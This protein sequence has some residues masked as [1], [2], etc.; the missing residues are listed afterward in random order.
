MLANSRAQHT[1]LRQ[2]QGRWA[3]FAGLCLAFLAGSYALLAETWHPAYALRWLLIS[4]TASVYLLAVTWRNLPGNHRQGETQLLPTL[5]W[6]NRL[7]LLRGLFT[8]ALLGFLFSPL[9]PAQLVW[10]PGILYTLVCLADFLDGY[11]A[12]VTNHVTRLGESLDMSSDGLGVL[13]A[14]LLVV[15]YGQVPAWYLLVGLARYLFLAGLWSRRR[16]GKMIYELPPSISR[17]MFAGL[18][19]GFLAV[20]LWPLFSPPGTHIA[21]AF[22]GTPLLAGFLLDWLS[23]CGVN[24]FGH[25]RL[26]QK[27]STLLLL[28]IP[29]ALRFVILAIGLPLLL[30]RYRSPAALA[31]EMLLLAVLE[32]IVGVML[33]LG[34]AGR[35]AA[36]MALVLL[37]V[38]QMY[39]SLTSEQILLAFAYTAILFIGSGALSLWTPENRLIYRRAG[40]RANATT[41]LSMGRSP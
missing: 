37:G 10:V 24:P 32:T 6:G 1:I 29:L 12:R 30:E 35:V 11:L 31:H 20:I 5:G 40:E 16:Q 13:G 3:L 41:R 39:A 25:S 18:Q 15:Q 21:A 19:M 7:T 9:P 27:A 14:V 4:T 38:N 17:R 26:T 33:V 28:W 36:I 22:F 2:L 34:A 8:A 23:V